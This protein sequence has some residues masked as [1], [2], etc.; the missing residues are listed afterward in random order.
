MKILLVDN[1]PVYLSLLAEVLT[2]YSHQVTTATDGAAALEILEKESFQLIIS[3]VSM[4]NLNGMDFHIKI[5]ES[6]KWHSIPFAWNSAY[7]E[8]LDVLLVRD[9][10]IDYKFDKSKSLSN[11]LH[12]VSRMDAA[13]RLKDASQVA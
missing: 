11:L 4:P 1:D 12:M 13:S 3:D 6:E 2:L 8:L 10:S 9:A 5:R 7:P